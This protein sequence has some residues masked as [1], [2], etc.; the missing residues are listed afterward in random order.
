MH[1][2]SGSR[3]PGGRRAPAAAAAIAVALAAAAGPA[4]RSPSADAGAAAG[5]STGSSAVRAAAPA[6]RFT[7]FVWSGAVTATSARVTARLSG[8]AAAVRLLYADNP[9]LAG[10][11]A[12]APLAVRQAERGHRNVTFDLADLAPRTRYHYALEIDGVRAD[13]HHGRFTTFAAGAQPLRVALGA[14]ADTGSE[15]GVFAAILQQAPDLFIHL[16]DLHYD[17]IETPKALTQAR[18]AYGAVL[19]SPRQAELFR[20]TPIAYV[21]DD[22]DYGSD[23]GDRNAPTRAA[24]RQAYVENVPHYPFAAP[25]DGPIH[26]AFSAGRVRFVLTDL[27]S[28]RSPIALPDDGAKSM[29]GPAQKAWLK[30]EL[31]AAAASHALVVWVNTVPWI[32]RE[33]EASDRWNGYTTERAELAA[34]IARERLTNVVMVSGDAHMLAIDDGTHSDFAP[35]GGAP[36]PVF[37]VAALDRPGSVKG[38]PYTLGP[39]PN[40]TADDGRNDGQFGLMEVDDDGGASVCLTWTGYRKPHDRNAL[41]ALLRWRRCFVVRSAL[42]D[43]LAL[44]LA[45]R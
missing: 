23:N 11:R 19:A 36:I 8:D 22:H 18:A 29:L 42:T 6:V 33:V 16:G 34:F 31:R 40:R 27:R 3:A 21:W 12:T 10:A 30:A 15:N 24:V 38:G 7:A 9:G 20:S 4:A 28:D 26:Q 1:T 44:P 13:E 43:W 14:C 39:F 32:V 41:A 17:A 35:G 37:H 45:V 5:A 25:G 2:P